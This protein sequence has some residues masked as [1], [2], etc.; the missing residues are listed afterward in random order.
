MLPARIS[1]RISDQAE[2][3]LFMW[4]VA[5]ALAAGLGISATGHLWFAAGFATGAAIALLGFVWLRDLAAGALD[6]SNGRVPKGL[7]LK[8]VIRY[9]LLFGTLY[10]FHRTNWLPTWAV[11]AGLSVPVAGGIVEGLYQVEEMIFSSRA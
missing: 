5:I 6:S 3:R 2:I 1:R 9:P 7:V 10:L 8:L 4:M 11:L